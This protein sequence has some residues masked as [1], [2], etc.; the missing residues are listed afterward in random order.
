MK[1]VSLPNIWTI[2]SKEER[3]TARLL[4]LVL[5]IGVVLEVVSFGALLLAISILTEGLSAGNLP[6]FS[7]FPGAERR[8][9]RCFFRRSWSHPGVRG[10][11]FI[12]DLEYLVPT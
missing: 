7:K 12:C 3:R 11:K 6:L 2:L 5:T 4:C 1:S 8:S 9:I 10:Q